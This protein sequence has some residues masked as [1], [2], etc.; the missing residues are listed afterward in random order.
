MD[1][2]QYL[3][4]KR[5]DAQKFA[6]AKAVQYTAWEKAFE[7]MSPDSFTS[8]KKFLINKIRRAYWLEQVAEEVKEVKKVA[9]KPVMKP[10]PAG[11]GA[12][13]PVVKPKIGGAAPKPVIKPKVEQG[14]EPK[15]TVAK[16]VMKPKIPGA[17][18][19]METTKPALKPVMKPKIPS[20][21]S[22]EAE[23]KPIAKPV[24]KPVIKK[25]ND[26]EEKAA[27]PSALK[28][29]IPGKKS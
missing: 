8:Q 18:K 3:A 20:T 9:A 10:K 12:A 4:S 17:K 11:T 19:E 1:F 25:A 14:E 28:P 24:M 15:K 29:K 6:A 13:K 26:G 27:K 23:K 16:P 2:K 5:I 7:Q 22:D 21:K